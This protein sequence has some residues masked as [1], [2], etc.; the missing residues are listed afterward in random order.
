MPLKIN[1]LKSK[2]KPTSNL[3]LFTDDKFKISKLK[4]YL[5]NNEFAFVSDLLKT[6]D[7]KKSLLVFEFNSKKNIILVSIKDKLKSADIEN[8]G[9]DLYSRINQEKN[10]DYLVLQIALKVVKDFLILFLHG[11]N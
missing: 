3:I 4:K 10:N 6:S 11:L 5:T 8:L 1:Y 2:I 7:L 9:A